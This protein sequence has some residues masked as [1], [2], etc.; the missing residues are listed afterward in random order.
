MP[1][2]GTDQDGFGWDFD[3]TTCAMRVKAWG[4]WSPEVA[5]T[6]AK[7]VI[8]ACSANRRA[9]SLVVD[10][11]GLKPQREQGQA[12]FG[13]LMAALPRLGVVRASVTTDSPLT[14]LQLMRL[15]KQYAVKNLIQFPVQSVKS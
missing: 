9:T 13:A 7:V 3:E 2:F 6:F 1:S 12:A 4:F 14:R 5:S 11:A 10:A 15:A 8:E